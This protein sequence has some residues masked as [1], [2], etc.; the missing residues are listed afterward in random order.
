MNNTRR[1][2]AQLLICLSTLLAPVQE[3][4]ADSQSGVPTVSQAASESFPIFAD[5]RVLKGQNARED[6]YFEVGKGRVTGANSYLDLSYSNSTT[7]LAKAS[8]ITVMMD[9]VPL[10]SIALDTTNKSPSFLR[11]DLSN[12]ALKA[13]FHKL[14]FAAHMELGVNICID[15]DNAANWTTVHKTSRLILSFAKA[16]GNVDLSWYPSPFFEK[17]SI[18]PMQAIVVVP[19][20]A[21]QAEFTSAAQLVQYFASQAT[22]KRIQFR[23]YPESELTDTLLSQYNAIWI[24]QPE[25]WK[26]RGQQMVQSLKPN[27]TAAQGQGLIGIVPSPWNSAAVVPNLV[28]S[29]TAEELVRASAILTDETLYSQLQGQTTFIPLSLK[30]K[31]GAAAP[32]FGGKYSVSFEKLGYGNISLEG[33]RNASATINYPIPSNWDIEDGAHLTLK[34]RHS[35]AIAYD[36]S[37]I[38]VKVN[39]IPADTRRLSKTSAGEGLLELDL[40][41]EWIGSRREINIE[42]AFQFDETD[43]SDSSKSSASQLADFCGDTYSGWA[44]IDKTSTLTIIPMPRHSI[45]LQSLPYPFVHDGTWNTTTFLLPERFGSKELNIAM[46]T[47]GLIGRNTL[48]NGANIKLLAANTA[49]LKETI[50]SDNII[51]IGPL[52]GLPE[53]LNGN[54]QLAIQYQGGKIVSNHPKVELLNDLQNNAAVI[55]LSKS[56]MNS[57]RGLLLL[58]ATTA[59]Q[60]PAIDKMLTDP[61]E[62]SKLTGKFILIDN[63]GK[64]FTF[65]AAAD[66]EPVKQEKKKA[67]A[68]EDAAL[69]K[70]SPI[71]FWLAFAFLVCALAVVYL[72]LRRRK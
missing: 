43:Q 69:P 24:G 7:L 61:L 59:E 30:S 9:D 11:L 66:P 52:N 42:V 4:F 64:V 10:Q 39:G 46:T 2:L 45:N 33:R 37:T 35:A 22:D 72:V 17:G 3:A 13:G 56:P 31:E 14:S 6:F 40:K 36:R 19:D 27:E 23:V 1:K 68:W 62:A 29:G 8:S 67:V 32:A 60:E 44:V 34:F 50:Q 5:D 53:F 55:H 20:D 54:E 38:T 49:N 51:Y 41:Q 48:Q 58:S 12:L 16:Y 21:Q 18:N 57:S 25:H 70:L 26:T 15:P 71:A 28:V 63:T 65:P 47:I